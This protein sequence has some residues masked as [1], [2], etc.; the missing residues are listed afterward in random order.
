[1]SGCSGTVAGRK[2]RNDLPTSVARLR[3]R[4]RKSAAQLAMLEDTNSDDH[5]TAAVSDHYHDSYTDCSSI[6]NY[7]QDSY[8]DY[9]NAP[10]ESVEI[11][12]F[13]KPRV[14]KLPHKYAYTH[15]RTHVT[16][17]AHIRRHTG[18]QAHPSL[19]HAHTH[20]RSFPPGGRKL[21]VE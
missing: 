7:D 10:T 13:E 8:T 9:Y 1:M 20:T 17:H 21:V 6:A 5:Q 11:V 4:H 16:M 19:P 14:A 18:M 2:P 3:S 12:A 15:V